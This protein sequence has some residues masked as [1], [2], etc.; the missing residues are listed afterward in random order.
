MQGVMISDL[1]Q[2]EHLIRLGAPEV[3][4]VIKVRIVSLVD[5]IIGVPLWKSSA[6]SSKNAPLHVPTITS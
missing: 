5:L 3:R 4:R 1:S 2:D 6:R